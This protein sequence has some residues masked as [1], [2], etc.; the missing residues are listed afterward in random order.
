LMGSDCVILPASL[1]R[2]FDEGI[3]LWKAILSVLIIYV[4]AIKMR[5]KVTSLC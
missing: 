1:L 3:E 5:D 4:W 2:D